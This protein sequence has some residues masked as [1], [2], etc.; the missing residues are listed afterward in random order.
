MFLFGYR[1]GGCWEQFVDFFLDVDVG[2]EDVGNNSLIF[3]WI[4]MSGRRML[5]TIR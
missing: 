4:W 2:T 1:D 5:G 3:F